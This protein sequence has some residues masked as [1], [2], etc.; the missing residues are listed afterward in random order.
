MSQDQQR[1]PSG[2]NPN[3]LEDKIIL[4]VSTEVSSLESTGVDVGLEQV[5]T[6]ASSV[7]SVVMTSEDID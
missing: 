6:A 2:T 7:K 4:I 1:R 3:L 5:F